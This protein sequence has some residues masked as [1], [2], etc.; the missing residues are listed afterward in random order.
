MFT[1]AKLMLDA[2]EPATRE[3][4]RKYG[5]LIARLKLTDAKGNPLCAA[6]RPPLVEWTA[7]PAG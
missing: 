6:V 4:A 2:V 1:R 3:A 5:R 7:S